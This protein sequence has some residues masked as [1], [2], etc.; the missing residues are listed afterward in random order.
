MSFLLG[1]FNDLGS[2][3]TGKLTH[4]AKDHSPCVFVD[5][6]PA[7]LVIEHVEEI[8]QGGVLHILAE[9]GHERRIAQTRP[10]ILNLLEKLDHQGVKAHFRT[11]VRPLGSVDRTL[12]TL[13]VSHHRTH[14]SAR[15]TA[16]H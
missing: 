10:D 14:H 11:A 16:T 3:R 12:E 6:G 15:K 7:R 1:K 4:I 5:R 13:Q 9:R 8:H 2:Q